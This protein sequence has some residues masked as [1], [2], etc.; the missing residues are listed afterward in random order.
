MAL[1]KKEF[2][3]LLP[4]Q[5]IKRL[6]ELEQKLLEE[7]KK[8]AAEIDS[9]IKKSLEELHQGKIAQRIAPPPRDSDISTVFSEEEMKA[10]I[11]HKERKE[12]EPSAP[13]YFQKEQLVKDYSV[14]KDLLG[15]ELSPGSLGKEQIKRLE[16]IN[17][18]I[19]KASYQAL[20]HS[21]QVA[22]LVSAT[23]EALYRVRKYGGIE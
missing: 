23:K 10:A 14:V 7:R 6:K 8:D 22:I 21:D 18:R 2:E 13:S 15:Y 20:S 1:D 5:R 16:D 9:L 17:T 19:S 3:K 11:P 4:E 12:D